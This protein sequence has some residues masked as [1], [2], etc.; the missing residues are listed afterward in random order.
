[1]SSTRTIVLR[2]LSGVAYKE[3]TDRIV[4][5]MCQVD[6]DLRQGPGFRDKILEPMEIFGVD[7]FGT[8]EGVIKAL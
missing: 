3:D 8:S 4:E 7:N 2:D 6:E 1:M 5:V